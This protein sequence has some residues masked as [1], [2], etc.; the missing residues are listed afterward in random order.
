M[1]RVDDPLAKRQGTHERRPHAATASRHDLC[2]CSPE[3][4]MQL[5]RCRWRY[6]VRLRQMEVGNHATAGIPPCPEGKD[7]ELV[8]IRYRLG[9]LCVQI[10]LNGL[11]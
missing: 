3:E 5:S 1:C 8:S 10:R 9:E 11:G 4:L 2:G 7:G 6:R